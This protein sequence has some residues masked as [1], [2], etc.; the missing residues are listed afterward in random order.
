M[1]K[2]KS[3]LFSVMNDVQK[4]YGKDWDH[5]LE[6][7]KKEFP[8]IKDTTEFGKYIDMKVIKQVEFTPYW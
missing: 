3:L 8:A 7:V 1:Q 6:G 2:H 5:F 4:W